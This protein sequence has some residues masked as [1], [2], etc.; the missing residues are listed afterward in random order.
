MGSELIE[1]YAFEAID[2][3]KKKEVS[4]SELLKASQ[5]RHIEVDTQ[6][7]ALPY[8]FYDKAHRNEYYPSRTT[9]QLSNRTCICIL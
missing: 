2:L 1:K 8:T 7:N 4:S 3:I 5:E 9:K 6:V